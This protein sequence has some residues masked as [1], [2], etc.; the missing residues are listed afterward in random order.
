MEILTHSAMSCFKNCRRK[1][2]YRYV[3]KLVPI[4]GNKNLNLGSAVHKGLEVYY[5]GGS[6]DDV[7]L[8]ADEILRPSNTN[9]WGQSDYDNLLI[10]QATAFGMLR[11]YIKYF[12]DRE[13]YEEIKPEQEFCVPLNNPETTAASKSFMHAG[14]IDGL[15]KKEGQ[16]WLREFKTASQVGKDYLERLKLDTQITSYIDAIQEDLGIQIVGVIY[17]ILKKPSIKQTQ[18][19]S[20]QDYCDRLILDYQNEAVDPKTGKPRIEFY[21]H[22]EEIHRNQNDLLE[23]RFDRWDTAKDILETQRTQ[24]YYRNTSLCS[25]YGSCEYLPLCAQ[26]Q[27]AMHLYEV[28]EIHEELSEAIKEKTNVS[29]TH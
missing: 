4:S 12:N 9:G 25:Q 28:K 6:D 2:Q 21:F 15:F 13:L 29:T 1:Y 23:W 10:Q 20:V 26:G 7:L 22:Q 17:T 27:A 3:Y 18:K 19:E 11:G 14:K 8:A 24:R 5:S 16:W